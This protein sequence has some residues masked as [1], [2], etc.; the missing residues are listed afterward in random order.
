MD[1]NENI[2]LIEKKIGYTFKDKS[3]LTQA[4]TRSSFCNEH[5]R[6]G[7]RGYMSN[8]VLEFF[9][10]SVLSTV[11]ITMMLRDKTE[12]YEH[13]IYT[14]LNE[15]D[16]SNIRS[17]LSDKRNLS[18]SMA[19]LGLQKY[20]RMGEGD[21]KL[22][23]E[24]EPSVME[25]LFESIIGAVYIDSNRDLNAV[26]AV[27]AGM[28][29][30][31]SYYSQVTAPIQSYKNALQEFCADKKHRLPAPMYKTVSES[32]PDHKRVYERAVLIGDRVV[33]T[34]KGKNQ[35]IADA[36]AAEAALEILKKEGEK[37]RNVN[38]ESLSALKS[39]ASK[40]KQ[41][42]P[43]FRD[44]G[45]TPSSTVSSREY[46]IE[47]R[48]MGLSETAV[49][50]SKQ[51]ARALAAEKLLNRLVIKEEPKEKKLAAKKPLTKRKKSPGRPTQRVAKPQGAQRQRK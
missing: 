25:D 35:K 36:A 21:A 7:G 43:E 49:G 20:L 17:K 2:S 6:R 34:G 4:F 19:A 32:G 9:G 51:E 45:E 48:C 44:L 5:K 3:L 13:G 26:M 28:L 27:V 22:G 14:S 12:R 37:H 24:N 10:D 1:F 50:K 42:S 41:P 46:M 47:C 18:G 39:F 16:F 38:F 30:V 11:I 23:V 33:A 29:D 8:E 40:N 31:S 15:G